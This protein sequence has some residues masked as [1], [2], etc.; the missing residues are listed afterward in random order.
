MGD[1]IPLVVDVDTGVDDALALLYLVHE[2]RVDLRAVTCVSGN[3]DVDQVLTNTRY[4]LDVAG[5][6]DI[7]VGR[8]AERPLI[9]P[10]RRSHAFHGSDGLGDLRPDRAPRPATGH[11]SDIALTAIRTSDRP[12]TLL[13]LGPLTN[14]A[15][16]L[17]NH[18]DVASRIE[19]V[20]FMGGSGV[21]GIGNAT[22]TAEF[23]A[24]HDPE[25]LA[26]LVQ[27]DVPIVMYGLDVFETARVLPAGLDAL[28]A[29]SAACV[30]AADL[31][32]YVSTKPNHTT[33]DREGACLGDAGAACVAADPDLATLSRYPVTVVLDGATRGQTV[34]DQRRHPGE[35]TEHGLSTPAR[36]ID[37]AV[38]LDLRAVEQTYLAALCGPAPR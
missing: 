32:G 26:V 7:P 9:G 2:P 25:A 27:A 33:G 6:H 4:V 38:D 22:P 15:L 24:W 1:P 18:P 30:L 35:D 23:N 16:L 5:A 8:G 3:T 29:G 31:L 28:R 36:V 21:G 14:V 17:R 20:V 13:A 10:P 12:V 34:L 37:V 11:A 19:R